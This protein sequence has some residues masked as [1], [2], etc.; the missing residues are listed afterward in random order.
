VGRAAAGQ[1]GGRVVGP[2]DGITVDKREKRVAQDGITSG[3]GGGKITAE[4]DTVFIQLVSAASIEIYVATKRVGGSM[5]RKLATAD[6]KI[7]S[8]QGALEK[9]S[10][11]CREGLGVWDL[12]CSGNG[13]WSQQ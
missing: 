8:I 7:V 12:M 11:S 5:T 3:C 13:V 6:R 4:L 1:S 9:G 2:I 10:I